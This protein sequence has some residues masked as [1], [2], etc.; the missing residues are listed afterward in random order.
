MVQDVLKDVGGLFY[1]YEM[2]KDV[3]VTIDGKPGKLTDLKGDMPA[4]LHF[5][6][7][8]QVVL[9]IQVEGPRVE[10]ILQAVDAGRRRI[11]VR[12]PREYLTAPDVPVAEN[13]QVVIDGKAGKLADL[14]PGMHVSLQMAA[15]PEKGLVIGVTKK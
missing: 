9:G 7:V 15:D 3:P 14:K 4:T 1:Q 2:I 13:V 5:S 8:K 10:C 11:T 12:L 6:A